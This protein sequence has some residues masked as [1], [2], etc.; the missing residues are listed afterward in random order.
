MLWL[1]IQCI[2]YMEGKHVE[3]TALLTYVSRDM[4]C[5]E[6]PFTLAQNNPQKDR[7]DC[8]DFPE[9]SFTLEFDSHMH[10]HEN[11]NICGPG[12]NGTTLTAGVDLSSPFSFRGLLK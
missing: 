8:R 2:I 12:N 3:C 9:Y 11:N 7:T 10:T 4:T 1:V 5:S 6:I